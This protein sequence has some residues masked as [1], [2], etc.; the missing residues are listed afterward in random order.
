MTPI[1][2]CALAL[3]GIHAVRLTASLSADIARAEPKGARLYARFLDDA[4]ATIAPPYPGGW[5]QTVTGDANLPVPVGPGDPAKPW[6]WTFPVIAGARSVELDL[7]AWQAAAPIAVERFDAEALSQVE[8]LEHGLDH[9]PLP[10]L[11]QGE[12][13]ARVRNEIWRRYV[14]LPPETPLILEIG[15]ADLD[16]GHDFGAGLMIGWFDDEGAPLPPRVEREH[17]PKRGFEFAY[18]GTAPDPGEAPGTNRGFALIEPREDAVAAVVVVERLRDRA[19]YA[20][21]EAR[22][23]P[24]D[25]EAIRETLAKIAASPRPARH[26]LV[27]VDLLRRLRQTGALAVERDCLRVASGCGFG[28]HVEDRWPRVEAMMRELDTDWL[29]ALAG[30]RV[31]RSIGPAN[32]VMMLAKVAVPFENSGGA[33]RNLA[34]ARTLRAM[35]WDA[36][37][38]TPLGYPGAREGGAL[39]LTSA[40]DGVPHLHLNVPDAQLARV[41]VTR[42]MEQETALLG[43]ILGRYG[44]RLIHAVSG[45]RG[46]DNALKALALRKR[47]GVPVLYD[48]RSFHEQAWSAPAPWV[49]DA[50]LTR[51]RAAQEDRCVREADRTVVISEAMKALLIERGAPAERISVIPNGVDAE[52][53][54]EV[55]PGDLTALRAQLGIPAEARVHGY[56]SNISVREGHA[57]LL[58]AH[59]LLRERHRDLF[60]LIVGDGPLRQT[61]ER[62]ARELGVGGSVIFA[63][64]APHAR[65]PL[66]YRL[67]DIFVVPRVR[68][69]AGDH[70]TPLKPFEAMAAGR[71]VVMSALPVTHEI[72]GRD[73][74]RGRLAAP[75]D[76]ESLARVIGE[77]LD[78]PD[79]AAALADR[80][81][82]WVAAERGWDRLLARYDTIYRELGG[83]ASRL[84][85]SS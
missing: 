27:G 34:T 28:A 39:P 31:E 3:D 66:H 9:H 43:A 10:P 47:F 51:L 32:R 22:V 65:I 85:D 26:A 76:A 46:Y 36:Y 63:G 77:L 29:P 49:A 48:L 35:G 21:A 4:G 73:G 82:A 38:I 33:V 57:T 7:L 19:D 75:G 41:P 5:K 15:L 8:L 68:D 24:A 69:F 16:E 44:A 45:N 59:A 71:P 18:L 58:E 56:V 25:P 70:V 11:R 60:C 81:R 12:R 50:E 6:T 61:I 64:E 67:F 2:R 72:V 79:Q 74:E 17:G 23:G 42:I 14:A 80:G 78:N 54:G 20:V 13:D 1:A 84:D 37:V 55:D 83:A 62:R 53:F 52:R 30:P 40:P